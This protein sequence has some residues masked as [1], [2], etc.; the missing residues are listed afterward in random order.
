MANWIAQ[1]KPDLV[2]L[3]EVLKYS[4]NNQP[5]IL[6]DTLK[7]RTGQT[8]YY[9]WVQISELSSGIGVAVLPRFPLGDT[10][11]HLL[12]YNRFAALVPVTANG[13]TVNFVS[14]HLDHQYSSERSPR[15]RS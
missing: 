4:S 3:N 6:I 12:S 15:S 14:T 10:A 7:A 5:Q 9:H 11:F 8:W 2:S 1:I 13:R